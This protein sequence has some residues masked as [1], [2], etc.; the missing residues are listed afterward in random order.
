MVEQHL[1]RQTYVASGV[2]RIGK[3]TWPERLQKLYEGLSEIIS[4][5]APEVMVIE[6]IFVDKNV[7]SA[8]K[9]GQVRGVAM[10][11]AA[12]HHLP[13]AE[14]TPRQVKKAVVGYGGAEKRQIQHMMQTLLKLS[15]LPQSDAA[16]AL[17]VALCHGQMT[18][19]LTMNK[20]GSTMN[21]TDIMN[22]TDFMNKKDLKERKPN[23]KRLKNRNRKG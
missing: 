21:K 11:V 20:G 15:G 18:R 5:H 16:D 1:S 17:A 2:V 7:A 12:I 23:S 10:V 6:K 9:L 8:L 14:Y 3:Y 13:V 19:G 4:L 22:R